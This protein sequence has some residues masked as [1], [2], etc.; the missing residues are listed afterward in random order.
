MELLESGKLVSRYCGQKTCLVCNRI[1]AGKFI[2]KYLPLI[3]DDKY[4]MFVVLTIQ[5]P[6][7]KDLKPQ[8]DRM[9]KF[10]N[11]SSI[12]RNKEYRELNKEIKFLRSFEA[13]INDNTKTFHPHFHILLA[14]DN[15]FDLKR[16]GGIL[17]EY[18]IKYFGEETASEY[19]QYIAPMKKSPLENFKYMMKLS[20]IDENNIG[21]AYHLINSL[22]YKRLFIVKNIKAPKKLNIDSDKIVDEPAKKEKIIKRFVYT[23]KKHNWFN[24]DTY[25]FLVNEDLKKEAEEITIEKRNLRELSQ[26]FKDQSKK[27]ETQRS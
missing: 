8:I 6:S 14:G 11:Q 22:D 20:E 1:R 27:N 19:A 10:F 18:W 26:F 23:D 3:E 25:E 7:S 12:K 21:L 24:N 16:Y 5:N 2:T 9:F 13:T 17:I 4:K 15:E